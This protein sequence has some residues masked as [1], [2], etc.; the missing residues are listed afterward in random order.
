MHA[1]PDIE[2][3]IVEYSEAEHNTKNGIY[4]EI[5]S[6]VIVDSLIVEKKNKDGNDTVKMTKKRSW[7][8]SLLQ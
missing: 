8:Q 3:N 7:K 6:A 5:S 2:V 4:R 1:L